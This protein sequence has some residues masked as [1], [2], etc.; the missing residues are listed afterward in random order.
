[1]EPSLGA[2]ILT[3]KL[4]KRNL[5]RFYHTFLQIEKLSQFRGRSSELL[6]ARKRPLPDPKF[7]TYSP[8]LGIER[9]GFLN[10]LYLIVSHSPY[11]EKFLRLYGSILY[12][13]I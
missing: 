7:L 5:T 9:T 8:Q 2:R 6:K 13:M 1:M 10:C 3:V 4:L 11:L 12:N